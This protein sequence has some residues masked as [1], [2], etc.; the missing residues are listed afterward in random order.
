MEEIVMGG[1]TQSV[2]S[3]V[4]VCPFLVKAL[5]EQAI[6]SKP[7]PETSTVPFSDAKLVTFK[8][9]VSPSCPPQKQYGTVPVGSALPVQFTACPCATAPGASA[10]TNISANNG[11]IL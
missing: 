7:L 3:P 5:P 4:S 11:T 6:V 10:E 1:F 2:Q 9:T 8:L